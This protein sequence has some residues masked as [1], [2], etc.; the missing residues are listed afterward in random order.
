MATIHK[1]IESSR[2]CGYRKPGGIYLVG[3]SIANACSM[4]PIPLTVCPCCSAGIK[5]TR[6]WTWIGRQIFDAPCKKADCGRGCV[7]DTPVAGMLWIGE[8]FYRTPTEFLNEAFKAGVSRRIASV[9]RG[10][11]IG[12]PVFLA[13]RK[14][15]V[16]YEDNQPEFTAGI[17]AVFYPSAIEYVV[18][19]KESPGELADLEKRGFTLVEVTRDIDA[20]MELQD[21][22]ITFNI[23]YSFTDIQ[24]VEIQKMVGLKAITKKDAR[25]QFKKTFP[26]CGIISIK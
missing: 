6:G 16:R 3:G 10:F 1:R 22:L 26:N 13:H 9:P 20:Q 11:S 8:A 12:D 18:T 21:Q 14:A 25:K 19:G 23:K 7:P 15:I 24:G 4:F 17:F 2:G 5:P